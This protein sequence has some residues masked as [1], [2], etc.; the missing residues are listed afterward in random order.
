MSNKNKS[1]YTLAYFKERDILDL[2]IAS[3]IKIL[4]HKYHYQKV[5]DV[6]CGSGVLVKYLKQNGFTAYGCDNSATA[7]KLAAK[8]CA[9]KSIK[10]ANAV[11][12]TYPNN[13]F[14]LVIAISLIEH[15]T[16][17]KGELFLLETKRILRPNG[18]VFL[19][20]P[21]LSTPV[22][23]FQK[24]SWFAYD[25]HTHIQFYSPESLTKILEAKGFRIIIR[26]FTTDHFAPFDWDMPWLIRRFPLPVKAFYSFLI[27]ETPLSIIR[28]SF[29]IGAIK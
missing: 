1:Y 10:R 6:G 28:N 22:R 26:K 13:S 23:L 16:L 15:L 21:N 25:D 5:L 8:I 20:T 12:L 29:W 2:H 17:F 11:K 14:D 4:M 9:A 24:D 3:A 7:V 18:M 27:S 19:I